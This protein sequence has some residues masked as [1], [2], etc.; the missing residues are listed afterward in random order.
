MFV[1]MFNHTH[2]SIAQI[3][4]VRLAEYLLLS[5]LQEVTL[6][7]PRYVLPISC[8]FI[9]PH[10]F[11]PWISVV[12]EIAINHPWAVQKLALNCLKMAAS[13]EYDYTMI[14]IDKLYQLMESHNAP[15]VSYY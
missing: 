2:F 3:S 8:H 9:R 13:Y 1:L 11:R 10:P 12:M 7:D 5:K 6:P 4:L 15:S 14:I